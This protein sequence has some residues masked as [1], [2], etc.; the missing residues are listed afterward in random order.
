MSNSESNQSSCCCCCWECDKILT[1]D[2]KGCQEK[3]CTEDKIKSP[4]EIY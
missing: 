2:R 1:A 3:K 4:G